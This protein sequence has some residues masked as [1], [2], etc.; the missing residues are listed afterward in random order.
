MPNDLRS[1]ALVWS[2]LGCAGFA[3]L[4][5]YEIADGFVGGG[6][7]RR[8]LGERELAPALLISTIFG[9]VW[10][11]GP[12]LVLFASV[13]GAFGGG[14][15]ATVARRLVVLGGG[16]FLYI[17]VGG[18]AIAGPP[19]GG[20]GT[21][22]VAASLLLLFSLG[23]AAR[24]SFQ[25]DAFV[26]G[27]VVLIAVLVGLFTFFPVARILLSAVQASDGLPSGRALAE[28]LFAAKIWR[29]DCLT[30]GR[31]CGVG[32]NTLLLALLTAATTTTL[33][34]A[35]ALVVTRTGFKELGELFVTS[36]AVD[37]PLE[38]GAAVALTLATRGIILIRP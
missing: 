36:P 4:P 29:L 15:R 25:G 32:W 20:A 3:L 24:G 23:L 7:L 18:V 1:W 17:L 6:W 31:S 34:L 14:D 12:G 30:G 13:V 28:R 5:W 21:V 16:G 11:L 9:R 37:A 33:G 22:V 8:M 27:A 26:A 19:G 10:L 35:F 2:V 38:P